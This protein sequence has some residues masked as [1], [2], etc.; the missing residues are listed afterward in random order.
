MAAAAISVIS[1]TLGLSLAHRGRPT[2]AVASITSAVACAEWANMSFLASTLGQLRF[3]STAT[4]R[5]PA[6]ASMAAALA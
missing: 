1:V 5:G 6:S 4:S 3:T 2:T